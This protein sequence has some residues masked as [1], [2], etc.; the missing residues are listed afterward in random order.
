MKDRSFYSKKELHALGFKQVG[1]DVLI[2]R[3]CSL[4]Y[5]ETIEI[6]NHVRID[7]FCIVSGQISIGSYIHISAYVG[8][9]G[10]Y[11]I[12]LKDFSNVSMRTIVLSA[13]DDF[14]GE[15]LTAS[16]VL[17]EEYARTTGGPVTLEEHANIGAACVI[18]PDITISKGAAIGAMSLV[19]KTTRPWSIYKGIPARFHKKRKRNI[20]ELEKQLMNSSER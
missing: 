13:T 16:P 18:F 2:S 8:L 14:S 7:D 10:K 20:L 11:K 1:S 15:F 4:Y 3:K 5:P 17:P 12:E 6:G 9:F 19:T